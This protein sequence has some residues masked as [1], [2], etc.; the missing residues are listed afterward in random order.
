MLRIFV[1]KVSLL[2]VMVSLCVGVLIV[3]A[4]GVPPNWT[5]PTIADLFDVFMVSAS[6]GWA[7]GMAGTIIRSNGTDWNN[8]TSPTTQHLYSVFMVSA[9]DRWAVGYRYTIP[10]TGGMIIHWDGNDWS[11]VK[12]ND[13]RSL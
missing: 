10:P 5:S 7:V 13:S 8:V 12:S 11:T 2:V 9:S 3:N 6:D 1:L 4:E